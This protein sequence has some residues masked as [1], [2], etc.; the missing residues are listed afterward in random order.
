MSDDIKRLL[1]AYER[2]TPGPW[3]VSYDKLKQAILV[4]AKGCVV[5]Y[6]DAC[7]QD[8]ELIALMHR[9]VPVMAARIRD[10]EQ[11]VA[12]LTAERDANANAIDKAKNAERLLA[13]NMRM[14]RVMIALTEWRRTRYSPRLMAALDQY[15][16]GK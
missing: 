13:E 1:E 2:G 7:A 14:R 4:D 12:A 10:L 6:G 3:L 15:D 16:G 8:V 5:I 9:T 11:Q